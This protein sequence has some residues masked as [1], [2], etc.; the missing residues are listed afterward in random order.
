MLITFMIFICFH[1]LGSAV[2]LAYKFFDGTW[3]MA[4][5]IGDG[6]DYPDEKDVLIGCVLLW[7]VWLIIDIV[8][9][10]RDRVRR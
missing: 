6:V 9:F 8:S 1:L 5:M 4:E 3:K 7:E 2:F 10:I